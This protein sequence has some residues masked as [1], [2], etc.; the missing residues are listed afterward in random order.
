MSEKVRLLKREMDNEKRKD[1]KE[2]EERLNKMKNYLEKISFKIDTSNYIEKLSNAQQVNI[3][4]LE[5]ELNEK[6]KNCR[7]SLKMQEIDYENRLEQIRKNTLD[8]MK[9]V[10]KDENLQQKLLGVAT[11]VS[12][13]QGKQLISEVISQNE[14]IETLLK[15]NKG[16]E[17]IILTLKKTIS[18]FIK[19]FKTY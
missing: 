4:N 14:H 2:S 11:A 9:N 10:R 13:V 15:K 8:F 6:E 5:Y 17:K 7:D 1:L 18:K 3:N 19:T 12:S 16:L